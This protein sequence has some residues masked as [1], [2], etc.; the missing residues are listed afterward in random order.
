[1]ENKTMQFKTNINCSGCIKAVTPFLN[2]V[3][4]VKNWEVNT[5]VEEKIL[6]VESE[7]ATAEDISKAV[8]SA[9]FEIE[10]K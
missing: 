3:Q 2:H 6:T 1:M 5:D 9:G 7:S 10:I 8:K 4:G